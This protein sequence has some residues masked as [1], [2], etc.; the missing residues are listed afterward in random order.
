[1]I[2]KIILVILLLIIGF[3]LL[4]KIN[5]NLKHKCGDVVDSFNNV[6]VYLKRRFK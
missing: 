3:K 1:M 6:N 5:F 2:K 4:I